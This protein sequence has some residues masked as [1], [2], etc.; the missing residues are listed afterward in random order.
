MGSLP[1]VTNPELA[2]IAAQLFALL[3]IPPIGAADKEVV[4]LLHI[5]VGGV[6]IIGAATDATVIITSAVDAQPLI[7]VFV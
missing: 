5:L 2:L 3:Q 7:V 1:A 4:V 6:E